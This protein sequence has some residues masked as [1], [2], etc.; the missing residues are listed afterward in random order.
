MVD[1]GGTRIGWSEL[2]AE[3]RTEIELMLGAPVLSAVSQRGGFSPGSA[4]RLVLADGRRA[5]VKAASSARNA[6]SV[7]LHRQEGSISARLPV[8][9]PIPEFLGVIDDRGWVAIAFADVEGRPPQEPWIDTEIDAAMGVLDRVGA[10]AAPAAL[11]RLEDELAGDFDGWLRLQHEPPTGGAELPALATGRLDQLAELSA[12]GLTGCAGDRLV[13]LDVRA[14]NLLIRADGTAVLVDWP[15]A[16]AGAAWVDP[17]LLLANVALHGGDVT[18]RLSELSARQ[19]VS[20]DLLDGF[21]AGLTGFMLD[22]ARRPGSPGIPHL[23]SFQRRQGEAWLALLAR[24]RGW[25][26]D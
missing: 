8:G 23:R 6:E 24:R 9:L 25:P 22:G 19:A 18:H 17:L 16:C 21:L 11:P 12:G 1:G 10:V 4:D 26:L 14:D 15:W 7:R 13:H 2:P 3:L 5:F 20:G